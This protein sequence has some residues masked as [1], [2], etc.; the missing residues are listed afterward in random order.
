MSVYAIERIRQIMDVHIGQSLSQLVMNSEATEQVESWLEDAA[1]RESYRRELAFM[2]LR[3][4]LKDDA[5]TVSLAGN[6]KL[7]DWDRILARVA[8]LRA[9]GGLPELDYPPSAD[10]VEPYIY[11]STF[12]LGQYAYGDIVRPSGVF[13]DCGACCGETAIWALGAGAQKVYAF[14]PNPVAFGYLQKNVEKFGGARVVPVQR[15]VGEA[16]GLMSMR[17]E[18]GNIGGTRFD[19]NATGGTSIPIVTLDGWRRENQVVPDFIKMDL[20]GWEMAALRGARNTI[21]EYRPRLAVCLYHSLS[22]MWTIPHLIKEICP[23]Y[24]F[25]CKKNAPFTEFVLYAACR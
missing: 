15:G 4:L 17:T 14:K 21:A 25:W 20:E 23:S 7:P 5:A 3:G 2:V 1:S 12:M 6:V 19:P 18:N 11:A 9:S 10:W 13:L 24:R 16:P 22:D 8:E